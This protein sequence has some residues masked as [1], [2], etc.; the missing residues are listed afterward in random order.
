MRTARWIVIQLIVTVAAASSCSRGASAL[1]DD[2]DNSDASRGR[3]TARGLIGEFG[4]SAPSVAA[5]ALRETWR[6]PH[7]RSLHLTTLVQ[8]DPH[9]ALEIYQRYL[10][11]PSPELRRAAL[12]AN[13]AL[14]DHG[15]LSL[16]IALEHGS[17]PHVRS[18][19]RQLTRRYLIWGPSRP[20]WRDR[21]EANDDPAFT[22]HDRAGLRAWR[23]RSDAWRHR[24][25]QLI[26]H[27]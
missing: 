15:A 14:W 6:P 3:A 19:A 23:R 22:P 2:S 18:G 9:S 4:T 10:Q 12:A 24:Q 13:G 1:S 8:L 7:E 20:T 16:L 21:K 27:P 25:M 26:G 17:D 5:A 11:D